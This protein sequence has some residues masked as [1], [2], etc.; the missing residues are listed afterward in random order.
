MSDEEIF[1]FIRTYLLSEPAENNYEKSDF[2]FDCRLSINRICWMDPYLQE[3]GDYK[4]CCLIENT[5]E[6]I[7]H[8]WFFLF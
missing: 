1:N 8:S 7:H 2:L 6:S 4:Y 5:G 3:E